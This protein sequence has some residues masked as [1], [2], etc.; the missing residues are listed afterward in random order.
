M[1]EVAEADQGFLSGLDSDY[2]V[3]DQQQCQ[4]LI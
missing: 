1:E 2:V 4:C 3:A